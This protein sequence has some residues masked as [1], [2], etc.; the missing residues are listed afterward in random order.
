MRK[1]YYTSHVLE[2]YRDQRTY[3]IEIIFNVD[4]ENIKLFKLLILNQVHHA[5]TNVVHAQLRSK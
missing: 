1:H 5:M 4:R 3:P 2:I